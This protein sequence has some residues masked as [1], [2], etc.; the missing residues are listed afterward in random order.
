[1]VGREPSISICRHRHV[2][3]YINILPALTTVRAA[4][5]S[6]AEG[7]QYYGPSGWGEL[8]GDPVVVQTT[9]VAHDAELATWLW[10]LS[11]EKTHADPDAAIASSK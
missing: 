7:G 1:M 8:R 4:T 11:K 5:D 9:P 2:N 10:D 6:A 3:D